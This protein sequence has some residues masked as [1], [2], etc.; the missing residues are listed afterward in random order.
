MPAGRPPKVLDAAA[1]FKLGL[2]GC[3]DAEIA[4]F[5]EVSTELVRQ[6]KHSDPEFLAALEKGRSAI[7]MSLRRK[8]IRLAL[9][10]NVTML[11]WL[12]K[13]LLGQSDKFEDTTPP[14]PPGQE[15]LLPSPLSVEQ[16]AQVVGM[17]REQGTLPGSAD[18]K[19][20]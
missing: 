18:A 9:K 6:R 4:A 5:H 13:Q 10:G 7:K 19:V 14:K 15:V 20:N 1:A 17:M 8:Q 11:V 16:H 3:T 12:G 2:L